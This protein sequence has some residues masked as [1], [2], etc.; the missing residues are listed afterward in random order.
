MKS[1]RD[2]F[3]RSFHSVAHFRRWKN[4]GGFYRLARTSRRV[5][6][7]LFLTVLYASPGRKKNN[8]EDASQDDRLFTFA[9]P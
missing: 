4:D 2:A 6:A 5:L 3:T 9:R 1:A 7:G 8:D